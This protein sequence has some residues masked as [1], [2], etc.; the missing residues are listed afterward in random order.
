[1]PTNKS[2]SLVQFPSLTVDDY[3]HLSRHDNNCVR[4]CTLIGLTE[5]F[6]R[7]LLGF[8]LTTILAVKRSR[9]YK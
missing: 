9:H 3:M 5:I 7:R 2:S 1:M 4:V 8:G 6:N